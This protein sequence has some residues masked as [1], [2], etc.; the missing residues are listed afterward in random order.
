MNW[1]LTCKPMK[2]Y[3]CWLSS[4][5][6]S[7]RLYGWSVNLGD[8]SDPSINRGPPVDTDENDDDVSNLWLASNGMSIVCWSVGPFLQF[9]CYRWIVFINFS[10]ICFWSVVKSLICANFQFQSPLVQ[11]QNHVFPSKLVINF[12]LHKIFFPLK[13]L[14]FIFCVY[15]SWGINVVT[16]TLQSVLVSIPMFKLCNSCSCNKLPVSICLF[17]T[18]RFSLWSTFLC[19]I[20]TS[21][22][23]VKK[24]PP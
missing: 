14:E 17:L 13:N 20:H 9:T 6:S 19:T 21:L 7:L 3:K 5:E 16:A 23:K 24:T 22:I 15:R 1:Q 18:A 10:C 12:K 8:P 2:L 4:V 11:K